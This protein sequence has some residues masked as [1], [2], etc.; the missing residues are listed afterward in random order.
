MGQAE[1]GHG[2][3]NLGGLEGRDKGVRRG[4]GRRES[5]RG[6]EWEGRRMGGLGVCG[7]SG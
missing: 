1:R 5:V 2:R 4:G 6:G 7:A 3:V